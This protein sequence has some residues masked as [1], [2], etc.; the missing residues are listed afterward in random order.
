LK[1]KYKRAPK[2]WLDEKK[3]EGLTTQKRSRP[4]SAE[5]GGKGNQQGELSAKVQPDWKNEA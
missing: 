5:R 2:A 4:P 3:R 1:E